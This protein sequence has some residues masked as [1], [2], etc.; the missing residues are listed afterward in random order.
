MTF[1][2]NTQATVTDT[3]HVLDTGGYDT[4]NCPGGNES[5]QWRALGTTGVNQAAGHLSLATPTAT[6]IAGV[7]YSE[8]ASLT[9]ASNQ[10]QPNVAVNFG[11]ANGP[12]AGRTGQAFTDSQGHATFTY[13]STVAGTDTI[14]ASLTNASGGGVT[15]TPVTVTWAPPPVADVSLQAVSAGLDVRLVLHNAKSSGP[16]TLALAPDPST[17][18]QFMQNQDGAIDAVQP[19]TTYGHD[20][21]TTDVLTQTEY[22]VESPLATDSST[23]PAAPA[24]V[25]PVT[26]T[27]VSTG[28]ITRYVSLAAD[29]AWL[30]DPHRTFPVTLDVP[31]ET[32][33][34]ALQSGVF[35]TLNSCAANR[36]AP[37]TD[38]V[39]G[40]ANNCTYHG[41]VYFDLASVAANTGISAASLY[42]YTPNQ[43]G[44]TGVQ[45][46]SNTVGAADPSVP[47][48]WNAA[49]GIGPGGVGQNGSTGHWQSWDVTSLVRQWVQNGATN[50][51][52]T[53]VGNGAPVRFAAPLGSGSADPALA[54]Y[55]AISTGSATGAASVMALSAAAS[56]SSGPYSDGMQFIYGDAGQYD[57]TRGCTLSVPHPAQ[58]CPN[59][60]GQAKVS[61]VGSAYPNGFGGQMFRL[62]VHLACPGD[63]TDP[64]NPSTSG[65]WTTSDQNPKT[66]YSTTDP[67]TQ[68]VA[69]HL[70]DADPNNTG[71]IKDILAAA[72][73]QRL[74]PILNLL[75]DD[76]CSLTSSKPTPSLWFYQAKDLAT[77]IYANNLWRTDTMIYFEIGNEV[78]FILEKP[79]YTNGT[80]AKNYQDGTYHYA[81]VFGHAAQGI[82]A[83][84]P[85][86]KN[87]VITAGIVNPTA[88]RRGCSNSGDLYEYAGKAIDAA[89]A[90][91]QTDV[92]SAGTVPTGRLGLGVHPYGYDTND[93]FFWRNYYNEYA[94]SRGSNAWQGNC[95]DL[96]LMLQAWTGSTKNYNFQG[97][98]VIFTETNWSVVGGHATSKCSNAAGCQAAYLVDLFTYLHDKRCQQVNGKCSVNPSNVPIRVAW[99]RAIVNLGNATRKEVLLRWE[100]TRNGTTIFN[101]LQSPYRARVAPGGQDHGADC[102]GERGAFESTGALESACHP[103]LAELVRPARC[104]DRS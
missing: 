25:G 28:A 46:Y 40:I 78:N 88:A 79:K 6:Q 37:T 9:D 87:R 89:R 98:P 80:A 34:A 68:K 77:Y 50:G 41:Q 5:L 96:N 39:V 43:T 101:R 15:A 92:P 86:A 65:W 63:V 14:T 85:Q 84:S 23:D 60:N 29:P 54:P 56:T 27:L 26:S 53:L 57:P 51:G 11:V 99:H 18:I 76:H 4:A 97:L 91:K 52:L 72:A 64:T 20:D 67:V 48:S 8:V 2:D 69:N 30:N 102:R 81:S 58:T 1:G 82:L 62:D 66:T 17:N 71:T 38:L 95:Q 103:G 75:P 104:D 83:G 70:V 59:P 13:T 33:S 32:A 94:G 35:G 90:I 36:L 74:T 12:N 49:P 24:N 73:A 47:T 42:L 3:A 21:V 22:T 55:L 93:G 44:A 16:F 7:P 19:I 31:I 100:T 45:V 10:P 61:A